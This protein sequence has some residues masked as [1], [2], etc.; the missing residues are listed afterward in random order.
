MVAILNGEITV[1]RLIKKTRR[2][3]LHDCQLKLPLDC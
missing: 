2:W 1:K 3:Y